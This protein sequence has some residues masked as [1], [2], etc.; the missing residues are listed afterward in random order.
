[1]D[2][3]LSIC[4]TRRAYQGISDL[5][6]LNRIW[7]RNSGA[8]LNSYALVPGSGKLN[9]ERI[10]CPTPSVLHD[11]A[12][13]SS[14]VVRAKETDGQDSNSVTVS[15]LSDWGRILRS[16]A[17]SLWKL[18]PNRGRSRGVTKI[19]AHGRCLDGS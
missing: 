18:Q 8:L 11:A 19:E 14:L 2:T 15:I 13:R 12:N 4:D 16:P 1:R 9:W 5:R 10:R 6:G 17:G 7:K 3:A